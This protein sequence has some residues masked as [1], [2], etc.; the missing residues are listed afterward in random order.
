[1][2]ALGDV[3]EKQ[4]DGTVT[5][6]GAAWI[7]DQNGGTLSA[8][9]IYQARVGGTYTQDITTSGITA[10]TTLGLYLVQ[11]FGGDRLLYLRPWR[12]AMIASEMLDKSTQYIYTVIWAQTNPD[13][14]DA[15]VFSLQ[16]YF[17]YYSTKLEELDNQ[18]RYW[19]GE[20]GLWTIYEI[21]GNRNF[22]LRDLEQTP[23]HIWDLSRQPWINAQYSDTIQIQGWDGTNFGGNY[24][25]TRRVKKNADGTPSVVDVKNITPDLSYQFMNYIGSAQIADSS[26]NLVS[27]YPTTQNPN[28]RK[29]LI[30]GAVFKSQGADGAIG[31][32]ATGPVTNVKV[33]C[34]D[35]FGLAYPLTWQPYLGNWNQ[36]LFTRAIGRSRTSIIPIAVGRL[37]NSPMYVPTTGGIGSGISTGI[38][39]V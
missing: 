24:K 30:N 11:N 13:T 8:N 27:T 1:M 25:F 20:T 35:P 15:E 39:G 33:S 32:N 14:T 23:Y 18:A 17:T 22:T 37:P 4:P 28:A 16:T 36:Y 34:E 19:M 38:S 10:P 12:Y 2:A 3:I 5:V 26:Y 31:P 6:I 21:N 29:Y 9:T 7:K